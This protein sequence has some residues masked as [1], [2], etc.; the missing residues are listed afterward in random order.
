MDINT[1]IGLIQN[2]KVED[3]KTH[4]DTFKKELLK[5]DTHNNIINSRIIK[6]PIIILHFLSRS[7]YY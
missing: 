6:H 4:Y 1:D 3:L 7:E 5:L 2:R